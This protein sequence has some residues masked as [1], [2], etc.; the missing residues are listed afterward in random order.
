MKDAITLPVNVVVIF[1][2]FV[3]KDILLVEKSM[4]ILTGMRD[5]K[6][7]TAIMILIEKY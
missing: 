6:Y 2:I 4:L 7:L 3:G 1:A 5:A